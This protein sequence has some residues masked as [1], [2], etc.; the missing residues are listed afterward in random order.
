[1]LIRKAIDSDREIVL[2][3]CKNTFEWG[4]YIDRVWDSW[5]NDPSGLLLVT[6]TNAKNSPK[7]YP[8]ALS[9]ISACPNNLAWIEGLRVNPDYRKQGVATLLV[10]YMLNFGI[11]KGFNDASAIVSVQ[12][13]TSQKMLEKQ[14]FFKLQRFNYYNINL[15]KFRYLENT[16]I[17]LQQEEFHVKIA[18][19]DDILSL[20]EYL[21]DSLVFNETCK[22]YFDSWKFYIF[23]NNYYDLKSLIENNKIFLITNGSNKIKG[24]MLLNNNSY[25]KPSIQVCYFD[26]IDIELYSKIIKYLIYFYLKKKIYSNIQFYLSDIVDLTQNSEFYFFDDYEK[27]F[28]YNKILM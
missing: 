25:H 9:R 22:R 23:Q 19:Y 14:G 4:D 13:T 5:I 1:M 10:K 3:F 11:K 8:I 24:L 6:E 16:D 2:D 27:F 21:K 26:C 7:G 12:N 28:I 15:E 17:K 20:I 18:D